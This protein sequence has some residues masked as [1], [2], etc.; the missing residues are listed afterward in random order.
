MAI[1]FKNFSFQAGGD[2]IKNSYFIKILG[3]YIQCDLKMDK[4]IN[5]ICSEL[6]HKIFNIRTLT[7]YTNFNTRSKFLNSFVMGKLYYM[8]PIYSLANKDNLQKLHK[9]IMTA[10]RAAIENF[11]FQKSIQYILTKCK[12]FDIDDLIFSSSLNTL[13]KILTTKK[14][15]GMVSYFRLNNERKVK[16]ISTKYIPTTEKMKKFYIYKFSKIYNSIDQYIRD[17]TIKG[18]KNEIKMCIR[19]GTINDTMD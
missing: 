11:C 12:W 6:H 10:A 7:P 8:V 15:P 4:T 14:P 3:T 18:F 13:H 1:F 17:K 16:N 2:T 9:V 19:A 5:K